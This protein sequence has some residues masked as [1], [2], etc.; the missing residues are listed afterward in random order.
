MK[1]ATFRKKGL[2]SLHLNI[3]SLLS[4]IDELSLIAQKANATVI[5]ISETKLDRS[6]LDSEVKICGY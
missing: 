5:G 4:K 6:A 3:D 1:I 2:H